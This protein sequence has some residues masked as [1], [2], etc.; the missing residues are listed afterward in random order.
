MLRNPLQSRNDSGRWSGPHKEHRI[1]ASQTTIKALGTSEIAMRH[2]N[3][4]RQSSRTG[5]DLCHSRFGN[6]DMGSR[7]SAR[8]AVSGLRCDLSARGSAVW[9]AP[10]VKV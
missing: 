6:G 4:C 3:L 8:A 7:L 9:V 5:V 10:S 1:D 2:L